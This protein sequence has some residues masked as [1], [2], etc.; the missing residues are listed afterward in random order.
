MNHCLRNLICV[1]A[2]WAG[3]FCATGTT[4]A[5]V[6]PLEIYWVDVEGGAATLVVTPS[7]ESVLIDSGN[8]GGRD[9]ARIHKVATRDAGL[10]QIDHLITTH[11]HIDHFGGAAELARLMPV[12]N[13]YDNGI[14][15]KDPDNNPD[16]ERFLKAIKPYREIASSQR[17]VMHAGDR[18]QLKQA[19]TGP[20]L[21]VRCLAARQNISTASA[22]SMTN[23]LCAESKA[24][25]KDTSDNANSIVT[26]LEFGDFQLFIGGDL[27]WNVE[28]QLVC[29]MNIVGV[30]DVYQVDHHG[31]DVSNNPLLV[32]SLA[33][34]VSIMSNGTKKGCGADTFATLK[35]T[36]SIQAMY[37]IHRNLR[38]DSQH[39]TA[40]ELIANLEEKCQ[41]NDIRLTVDPSA[42]SYTVSIP[43]NGHKRTFQTK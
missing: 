36:P 14:P 40:A 11:F 37:Q 27:T 20:K 19:D 26:L 34:T 31:L 6:K 12:I 5:A 33:P 29:P 38:E 30:V 2:L 4:N 13:I 17:A 8:P 18:L 43:A 41:A 25:E 39:N 32:R 16:N 22:G 15:D 10:K 7:G 42:K 3:A 9:S 24:K 23:P 35:S 28:N 1:A 21:S